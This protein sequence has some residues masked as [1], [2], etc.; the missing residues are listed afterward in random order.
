MKAYVFILLVLLIPITY[1]A[2]LSAEDIAVRDLR[3]LYKE[4][5]I[6]AGANQFSDYWARDAFFASLGSNAIEDFDISKKNLE[7]FIR[8]QKEAGQIPMRVGNYDI[9][10]KLLGMDTDEKQSARYDQDKLFTNPRDQNCLFVIAAE[11]YITKSGDLEFAENNFESFER[12]ITWL[13]AK[14]TNGNLLVEEGSYAGWTDSVKKSGEVLYT[15]VCYYKSLSSLST[16]SQMINNTDKSQAYALWAELVRKQINSNFWVKDYYADWIDDNIKY[17]Y[18]STDA[19]VLA[20]IWGVADTEKSQKILYYIN[21][22]N[23]PDEFGVQTATGY[24]LKRVSLVNVVAGIPDY[25]TNIRWL[26]VSCLYSKALNDNNFH[27]QANFEID[28]IKT[29]IKKHGEVYEVY[30]ADGEPVDRWFYKAEH[31]FAWSS[32]VCTYVFEDMK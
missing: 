31:P 26:W 12:A 30:E 11:D 22:N 14:D 25:H 16:I 28:E 10:L 1:S 4:D 20:I 13:A 8:Y 15:N 9:T 21:E 3:S 18:F 19:N 5:G 23:L 32:G 6:H 29:A 17:T 27:S 7:L 2:E 24:N